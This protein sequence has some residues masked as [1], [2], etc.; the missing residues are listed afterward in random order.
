MMH[1]SV[2]VNTCLARNLSDGQ[3]SPGTTNTRF[4]N[5][6]TNSF[7]TIIIV[8]LSEILDNIYQ[9]LSHAPV[10]QSS[11]SITS[12]LRIRTSQLSFKNSR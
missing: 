11:R 9:L 1:T 8:P 5:Y 6:R 3:A 10:C 12:V 7:T 4:I 2:H